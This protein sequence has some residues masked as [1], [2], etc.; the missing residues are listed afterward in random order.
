MKLR[1]KDHTVRLRLSIGELDLLCE[2]RAQTMTTSLM[3]SELIT[4][5]RPSSTEGFSAIDDGELLIQIP[6]KN[7][8]DLKASDEEGF[9]LQLGASTIFIEKDFKCIGRSEEKNAGLF[10]NPKETD[11]AC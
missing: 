7:L 8:I 9:Q 4:V 10:E 3:N 11:G 1:I 2:G 5:I 6:Q